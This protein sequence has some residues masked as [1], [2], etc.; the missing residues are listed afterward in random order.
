M[1]KTIFLTIS[2]CTF[3]ASLFF[4]SIL[5]TFGL[6]TTSI[7]SLQQLQ[8]S[9]KIVEK[10]KT[11]HQAKKKNFSKKFTKRAGAKLSATA[12]SAIP[13]IGAIGAVVAISGLEASY[14]CEDKKELQED[15][16]LLFDTNETFDNEQ[17]LAEAQQDSKQLIIEVK[18][19]A[20]QS[21][22]DAWDSLTD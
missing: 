21:L 22:N 17:C 3:V 12:T 11:R 19:T 15:E 16:N 5:A 10:M 13:V 1:I 9:K 18:E 20:S 8:Q 2:T 7:E 6:V 4:N 14:Y